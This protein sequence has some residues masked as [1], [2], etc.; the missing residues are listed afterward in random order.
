MI[1]AWLRYRGNDFVASKLVQMPILDMNMDLTL[2]IKESGRTA[3]FR[4]NCISYS[5]NEEVCV[6]EIKT[7]PTTHG[8]Q[9]SRS[10]MVASGWEVE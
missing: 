9:P 4:L 6:A 1:K 7:I 5:L 3:H 2:L 10:D 8:Y